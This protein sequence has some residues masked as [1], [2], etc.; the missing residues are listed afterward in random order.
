M[1]DATRRGF[2][3]GV[4]GTG[5]LG[6]GM[7]AAG[8]P[9]AGAEGRGVAEPGGTV[10]VIHLVGGV[11]GLSVLVP[12]GDPR[13]NERRPT[14]AVAAPGERYG[15]IEL[16][17][18]LGLHPALAPIWNRLGPTDQLAVIC[19]V[20]VPDNGD[21]NRSHLPARD[22]LHRG[23]RHE[24]EGWA[25]RLLRFEGLDGAAVWSFGPGPHPMFDGLAGAVAAN[26]PTVS[27]GAHRDPAGAVSAVSRAYGGG[28]DIGRSGQAALAASGRWSNTSWTSA[29][30]RLARGYPEG[31]LGRSLAATADMIREDRGLRLV[32]IDHDGYDTHVDQGGGR[33]GVLAHRLDR[34]ARGLTAFWTD[35]EDADDRAPVTVVVVSE[36]GRAIDE[37]GSGGTEHGRGGVALA[38]GDRVVGGV[39]GDLPDLDTDE[40]W[41]VSVDIRRV[42][43]D[44]VS[45]HGFRPWRG[46]VFP[47]LPLP[48]R[49]LGLLL[50]P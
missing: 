26:R 8:I 21:G 28:S 39:H 42:C 4:V 25:S 31:R 6:A 36:F 48:N 49:S 7:A 12:H 47:G 35:V 34:L 44:A 45:S 27:V 46:G 9:V 15:A 50:S 16:D 10:V 17:R 24:P 43:A 20:G 19:G 32:A 23:G 41:P 3:R 33:S 2:L 30:D 22:F 13:Y 11:D 29:A 40:V 1:M 38:L 5:A 14:I 37:N 18:G